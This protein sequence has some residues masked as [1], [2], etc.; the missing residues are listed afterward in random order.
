MMML[1][2]N[3][4]RIR[5]DDPD[6]ILPIAMRLVGSDYFN[7]LRV[8][9]LKGRPFDATD[10]DGATPVVVINTRLAKRLWPDRGSGREADSDRM[11]REAEREATVVG[12]IG[13]VHYA[14][15]DEETG[16]ELY[17]PL[18]QAPDWGEQMWIALRAERN[19]L[20]LAGTVREAVRR[21]DPQQ[22]VAE[23]FSLDQAIGQS[24]AA[25]RFNMMLISPLRRAGRGALGDRGVRI[26]LICRQPAHQG[27]GDSHRPRRQAGRCRATGDSRGS[28]ACPD[29][30][31]RSVCR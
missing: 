12:V 7:T 27:A 19:P 22:P 20:L 1:A 8:P 16:P 17:L 15:L 28:P 31:P 10:R 21:A 4:Q 14:G 5:P 26:D 29:R 23:L 3:P 11:R 9:I 6:P 30:V 24:T 13:D 2:I 25:R 18:A